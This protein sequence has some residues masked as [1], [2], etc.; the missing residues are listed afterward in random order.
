MTGLVLYNYD[1]DANCY[2]VRVAL[3]MLGLPYQTVA[4]NAF[5]GKEHK[6]LPFLA[7]NPLGSLPILKDGD[8]TL[9]GG[10][11]ILSHLAASHD[12]ARTWL[13]TGGAD[14]AHVMQWL[15]F[16]AG[17]LAVTASA[18]GLSLFDA[19]GDEAALRA[20]A[21]EVLRV[22][23]DHLTARSFVGGDWFAGSS[24]TIADIALF[25]AFALSRDFGVDHDEYP[26]LR[27]WARR[28]RALPGFLTMPGIPD[29]H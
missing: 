3:S 24:P 17:E 20:G 2:K 18:R 28:F 11:A 10:E 9:F 14:F 13:P 1:L 7:M 6:T 23:D 25:P 8:I 12:P 5:P 27:R 16:S 19:P 26:A 15:M 29:Y 21:R 22:M 4:V